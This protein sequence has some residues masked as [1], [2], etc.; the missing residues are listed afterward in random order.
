MIE[1]LKM[2]K[3]TKKSGWSSRNLYDA[4]LIKL[5]SSVTWKGDGIPDEL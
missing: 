3:H 1:K 2:S 4:M 5:C